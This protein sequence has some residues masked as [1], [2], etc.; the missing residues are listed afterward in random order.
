[1]KEASVLT[2]IKPS[3]GGF[4][5]GAIWVFWCVHSSGTLKV[6]DLKC[7]P[8]PP[9]FC[10]PGQLPV[11]CQKENQHRKFTEH[12]REIFPSPCWLQLTF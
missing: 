7:S 11:V 8:N 9:S 4:Q 1:M 6:V 2:F 10:L 5:A 3:G 12:S